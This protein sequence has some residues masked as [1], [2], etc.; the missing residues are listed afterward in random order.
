MSRKLFT[1]R[2][3]PNRCH[4]ICQLSGEQLL[5]ST[6]NIRHPFT[7]VSISRRPHNELCNC[8]SLRPQRPSCDS[9]LSTTLSFI[10]PSDILCL[11]VSL[12]RDDFEIAGVLLSLSICRITC[13]IFL[14]GRME[15]ILVNVKKEGG[16]SCESEEALVHLLDRYCHFYTCF[17]IL[18]VSLG[19]VLP[20][21]YTILLFLEQLNNK[22]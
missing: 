3:T 10:E 21:L 4:R 20:P 6:T 7:N 5:S 2:L 13:D 9:K 17:R 8:K 1:N 15:R 12:N 18:L 22:K 14:G 16:L 19:P 11:L